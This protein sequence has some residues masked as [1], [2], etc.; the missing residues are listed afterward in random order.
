MWYL[1]VSISDLCPLSYFENAEIRATS[2][3]QTKIFLLSKWEKITDD[4]WVL[5]EIK[6]RY[7]LEFL[8]IRD[9]FHVY[10]NKF[11]FHFLRLHINKTNKYCFFI[12]NGRVTGIAKL[13]RWQFKA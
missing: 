10:L 1:I 6:H 2:G 7:K 3:R 11:E 4:Q 12:H 5:S 9:L 8:K 13:T